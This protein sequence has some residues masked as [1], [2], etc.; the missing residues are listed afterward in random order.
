MQMIRHDDISIDDKP[1]RLSS[2]IE[3]SAG[4]DLDSIRAKYWQAVFGDRGEIESGSVS[5]DRMHEAEPQNQVEC[6][7][8]RRSLSSHQAAEPQNH[9]SDHRK[10]GAFP[11]IRR[12]SRRIIEAIIGKAEPFRHRTAEP[13]KLPALIQRGKSRIQCTDQ[14]ID[15]T[16]RRI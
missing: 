4:D 7:T 15:M 2:F 11:H 9:R 5:R 1:A 10:G 12:Q 6:L 13:R 14:F 16:L 3:S 8:E